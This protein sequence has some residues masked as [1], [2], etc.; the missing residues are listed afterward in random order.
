LDVA[1]PTTRLPQP[2]DNAFEIYIGLG[3]SF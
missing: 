3:Q 2:Y 1:V